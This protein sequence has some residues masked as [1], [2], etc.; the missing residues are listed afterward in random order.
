MVEEGI[1]LC[2]ERQTAGRG[3]HGRSWISPIGNLSASTAV[4]L[5]S[6]GPPTSTLGFVAAVALEEVVA[7]TFTSHMREGAGEEM[8]ASA[9]TFP[10]KPRLT[11]PAS[12][13]GITL[14]WPN[15]ILIDGAKL[16]GI[17]LER[18]EDVVVVGI[19]VNLAHHPDLPE[20]RTTSLAA[21]GV[22]VEPATFAEMLARSFADWLC[23]WR[24]GG[25]TAIRQRWLE[26]A[27]PPGIPLRATLPDGAMVEG[28]FDD[29]DQAGALI[30]RLASGE[31][32]AIYA[33]DV[34]MV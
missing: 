10:I 23:R 9:S 5:R 19:G 26:R 4:R 13:R 3:R 2:A 11:P 20:R 21:H 32:R 27:H 22:A 15:D 34:F 29:I 8:S 25:F 17:L 24:D 33:G 30:L 7:A 1:W 6:A 18:A 31:R 14:K 28:V 12:G 16:S